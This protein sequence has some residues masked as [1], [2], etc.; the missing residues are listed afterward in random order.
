MNDALSSTIDFDETFLSVD[1]IDSTLFDAIHAASLEVIDS[2]VSVPNVLDAIHTRG[3][4]V[5]VE[6]EG[7]STAAGGS[8]PRQINLVGGHVEVTSVVGAG[9]GDVL[10]DGMT[11]IVY[12]TGI[13]CI[14]SSAVGAIFQQS[15]IETHLLFAVHG[16][17]A[18][19]VV[20]IV[21]FAL[22]QLLVGTSFEEVGSG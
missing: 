3:G 5:E 17:H 4:A 19:E 6:V 12:L 11:L 14:G 2:R 21:R 7:G 18:E 16:L 20:L 15:P 1:D 9:S 10:R 13:P 22:Y 8:I